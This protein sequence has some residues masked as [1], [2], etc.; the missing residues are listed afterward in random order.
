MAGKK[1]RARCKD[2]CY[3]CF[4]L[5]N[6][7]RA[8]T[9]HPESP[10]SYLGPFDEHHPVV[11]EDD[12]QIGDL[13]VGLVLVLGPSPAALAIRAFFYQLL[14]SFGWSKSARPC[15]ADRANFCFRY[16]RR[17]NSRRAPDGGS[18]RGTSWYSSCDKKQ[19]DTERHVTRHS[20][21]LYRVALHSIVVPR[22][23]PVKLAGT[24]ASGYMPS[25]EYLK[26]IMQGSVSTP[27]GP[28]GSSRTIDQ[29]HS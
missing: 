26:Y 12:G 28:V 20:T 13:G 21:E 2:R 16:G 1:H 9:A 24:E 17:Q 6:L 23:M 3:A 22:K 27:G 5:P 7:V 11:G 29:D 14:L 10:D 4:L 8:R 18:Y 19:T 15:R 25:F